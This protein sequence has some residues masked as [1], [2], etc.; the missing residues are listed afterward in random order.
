MRRQW[1]I[2]P[3]IIAAIIM[4]FLLPFA[5]SVAD[6]ALIVWGLVIQGLWIWLHWERV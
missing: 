3:F 6:Y 4:V 5:H 2:I 1:K